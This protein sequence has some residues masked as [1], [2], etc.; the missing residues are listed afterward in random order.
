M[1][2]FNYNKYTEYNPNSN[3]IQRLSTILTPPVRYI[4]M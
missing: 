1:Y 3:Y 2:L 4:F